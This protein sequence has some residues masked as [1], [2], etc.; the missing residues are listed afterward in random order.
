MINGRIVILDSGSP[1]HRAIFETGRMKILKREGKIPS[2]TLILPCHYTYLNIILSMLKRIV[3]RPD[4]TVIIACDARKSWRKFYYPIYKGNRNELRSSHDEINWTEEYQKIEEI[5]LKLHQATDWHFIKI[6]DFING[7][8]IR[9]LSCLFDIEY[10]NEQLE[11][12][13]GIEA[14]DIIATICKY[15][16]DKEIVIVTGDGDLEM[17]CEYPNVKYFSTN[18]KYKKQKGSWKNVVDPL[19]ILAKKIKK[20]DASDNI[21]VDKENDTDREIEIR[22]LIIDL[23]NL[24]SF[25]EEPIKNII[26]HLP[27][28]E[29]NYDLMPL[30]TSL[31]KPEKFGRIYMDTNQVTW[32]M[33][34]IENEKKLLEKKEKNKER[35]K[36][37]YAKKKSERE[38]A[39]R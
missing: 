7:H 21:L 38:K 17:L 1:A 32:E 6:S 8:N 2:S 12:K 31:G 34:M 35:N 19:K 28:K 5:N 23:F 11:N 39:L 37:V 33:S 24:P 4:D 9:N 30:Q 26:L 29:M 10:S 20:G 18:L 36:I 13:Y 25:V 22:K 27:K 14:D 16:Q 15:N 3:I